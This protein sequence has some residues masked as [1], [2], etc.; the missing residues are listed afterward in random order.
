MIGIPLGQTGQ[1]QGEIYDTELYLYYAI[2]DTRT[3][4]SYNIF[5][6]DT[7][8]EFTAAI[9]KYLNTNTFTLSLPTFREFLKKL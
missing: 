8:Q 2:V 5:I 9:T 4:F 1:Y 3:T 6:L 7:L